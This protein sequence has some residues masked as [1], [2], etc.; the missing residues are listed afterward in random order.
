MRCVQCG[1]EAAQGAAFC[2]RCGARVL[3]PRP[4][5]VREYA[6]SR[7]L[8]SWWYFTRDIAIAAI[9]AGVGVAMMAA[10]K[11]DAR[12]GLILTVAAA[13]VFGLIAL[14]RSYTSWSLTS[15]R[16]IERR[17]ILASRRREMELADVRSI[18][19]TRSLMQRMLGLGNVMIASA[20][21]AE[22]LIRLTDIPDPEKVAEML[23]QARLK[24]LA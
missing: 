16:L 17:G 19:V 6:L 3:G 9:M 14:A 18:E 8:P 7:I 1:A 24:R 5:A 22:F 23:R 10:P 12:L 15:D 21:S 4:S 20:A 13:G 11:G 2:S